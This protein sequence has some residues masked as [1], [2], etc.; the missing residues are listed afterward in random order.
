VRAIA[1]S[2]G[3]LTAS[4]AAAEDGVY[5][6]PDPEPGPEEVLLL[7]YVNRF[8]SDPKAEAARL[9]K[10]PGA[11]AKDREID[12]AM[13]A[14]ELA[15]A[16]PVPPLVMNAKL[17][18]AARR[19]AYYLAIN[20]K[21]GHVEEDE[22]AGFTGVKMP[23]RVIEA[24]YRWTAWWENVYA[25]PDA[26]S[27]HAG[28]VIDFSRKGPG[29]M[30]EGRGHR[31]NI[32]KP[33]VREAGCGVYARERDFVFTEGFADRKEARRLAGGV[34]FVDRDGDGFYDVGEGVGGARVTASDGTTTTTWKSGGYALELAT[35][36][37]VTITITHQDEK[38]TADFSAGRESVKLDLVLNR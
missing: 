5:D 13:L 23:D 9:K 25:A 38:R 27:V 1:L 12:W 17:V 10:D 7:E 2:V 19:H 31:H 35:A 4:A 32:L 28:F 30:L 6:P 18:L 16:Q 11:H 24:G 37:A 15:A 34:V 14:K 36:D 8:R 33:E 26:W 3:V 22:L 29:G 21:R 20:D